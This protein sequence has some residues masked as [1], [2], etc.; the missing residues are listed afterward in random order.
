ML[1]LLLL[2]HILYVIFYFDP[3]G[4]N[5]LADAWIKQQAH[6]N[7]QSNLFLIL[8]LYIESRNKNYYKNIKKLYYKGV[9]IKGDWT[10]V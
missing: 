8:H 3:V 10:V 4:F 6:D 9:N 5:N 2:L 1:G 7:N